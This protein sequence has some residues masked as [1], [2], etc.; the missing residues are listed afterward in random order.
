M[1][2]DEA[3]P[4][5]EPTVKAYFESGR[6][7]WVVSNGGRSQSLDTMALVNRLIREMF[8]TACHSH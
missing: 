2:E 1:S 5:L 8:F 7:S 4:Y 6:H 3:E